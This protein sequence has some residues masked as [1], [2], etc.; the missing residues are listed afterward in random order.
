M[1]QSAIITFS[2]GEKLKIS[3]GDI[4][5]TIN[6]FKHSDEVIT[7]LSKPIEIEN[8]VHDGLIPSIT[9][10]IVNNDFF[11]L[12]K[13]NEKIYYTKSIVSIENI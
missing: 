5:F 9:T 2:N 7:S 10:M 13:T 1:I 11:T 6:R 3:E 12:T 8:H 4:I